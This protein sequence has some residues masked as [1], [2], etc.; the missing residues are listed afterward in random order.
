MLG[1]THWVLHLCNLR[2]VVF[3]LSYSIRSPS[4]CCTEEHNIRSKFGRRLL[5]EFAER[6]RI[7]AISRLCCHLEVMTE[8][9]EK[10]TSQFHTVLYL[11]INSEVN[12][13]VFYAVIAGVNAKKYFLITSDGR[14][15]RTT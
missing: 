11:A 2:K 15:H 14:D 10:N 4:L 13:C 9:M 7:S 3:K 1:S 8:C 6:Y 5:R 12:E